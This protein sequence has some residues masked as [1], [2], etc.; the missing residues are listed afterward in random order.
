MKLIHVEVIEVVFVI[1]TPTLTRHS[2][3]LVEPIGALMQRSRPLVR[4]MFFHR[5]SLLHY[6]IPIISVSSVEFQNDNDNDVLR[7]L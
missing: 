6:S 4:F 1:A 3:K 5:W 7:K 2:N